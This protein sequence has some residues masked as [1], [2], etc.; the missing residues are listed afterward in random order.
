[1]HAPAALVLVWASLPGVPDIGVGGGFWAPRWVA[2]KSS[3]PRARWGVRAGAQPA[4]RCV[5]R[6]VGEA[7]TAEQAHWPQCWLVLIVFAR[8]A[9]CAVFA[10]APVRCFNLPE[11][12]GL[13]HCWRQAPPRHSRLRAPPLCLAQGG[14]AGWLA[15][16][17]LR[18]LRLAQHTWPGADGV[19]ALRAG[20]Q[21]R[22][23]KRVHPPF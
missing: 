7:A 2:A 22:G 14:A 1:M 9:R 15:V 20:L 16:G 4:A 12:A 21:Q 13:H 23:I 19:G 6:V 10:P 5:P 11:A 3:P 17:W 8:W 18:P